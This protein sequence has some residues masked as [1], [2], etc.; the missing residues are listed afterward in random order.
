[1]A[2]EAESR[3]ELL[4]RHGLVETVLQSLAQSLDELDRAVEQAIAGR[5]AHVGASACL[6]NV[7]D[8]VVLIVKVMDG[9]NRVRFANEPGLLAEWASLSS[10]VATP[11]TRGEVAA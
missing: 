1:M 9:F 4:V 11:R 8:E 5:R 3:R 2:V 10:V 6:D 7:A